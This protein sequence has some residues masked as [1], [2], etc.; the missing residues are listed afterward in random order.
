M[1]ISCQNLF[2]PALLEAEHLTFKNNCVKSNMHRP[3]LSAAEM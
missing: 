2:R 1:A 3:M